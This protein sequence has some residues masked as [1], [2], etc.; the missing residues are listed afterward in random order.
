[1][2]VNFAPRAAALTGFWKQR[3]GRERGL[4]MALTALLAG[5]GLYAGVLRPLSDIRTAALASIA[6]SE[7]ALAQLASMPLGNGPQ[8][9]VSVQPITATVTET[10]ADH[11]L[12]IRRM[13]PE[14]GG[15][16]LT[17]EDAGFPEILRWIEALEGE[18]G[19]RVVTLEMDRRPA[20][21]VVSA[22][23]MVQR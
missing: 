9:S 13:E 2:A 4:L 19:L 11:G 18:Y 12:T 14:G 23:L 3:N 20:P 16:R 7:D 17:V 15:A 1:M 10:A 5:Y 22:N 21:G 6:R 8:V